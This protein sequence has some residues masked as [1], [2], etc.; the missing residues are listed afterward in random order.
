M[1]HPPNPLPDANCPENALTVNAP[2]LPITSLIRRV[3]NRHPTPAANVCKR[4]DLNYFQ[5]V[6]YYPLQWLMRVAKTTSVKAEAVCPQ[7]R[8]WKEPEKEVAS[9]VDVQVCPISSGVI[10]GLFLLPMYHGFQ[11]QSNQ[12]LGCWWHSD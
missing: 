5:S 3:E 10:L 1:R 8:M 2:T 9:W 4:P 6:Y 7:S 12:R 11:R